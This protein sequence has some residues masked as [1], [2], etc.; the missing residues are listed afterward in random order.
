MNLCFTILECSES[1]NHLN[2]DSKPTPE[3]KKNLYLYKHHHIIQNL[4]STSLNP[5]I[6][7]DVPDVIQ[8]NPDVL[9]L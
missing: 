1:D 9:H 2:F 7:D 6:K 3:E 8:D 5:D 4:I